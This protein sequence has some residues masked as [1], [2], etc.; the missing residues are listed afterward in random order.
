MSGAAARPSVGAPGQTPAAGGES[1]YYKNLLD[2]QNQPVANVPATQ[3]A[4]NQPAQTPNRPG[5][6]PPGF[7]GMQQGQLGPEMSRYQGAYDSYMQRFGGGGQQPPQ[8]QSQQPP[9][10]APQPPAT[11]APQAPMGQQ[12]PAPPRRPGPDFDRNRQQPGTTRR[13]GI[14]M[15]AG[16]A[17]RD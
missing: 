15:G 3:A 11:G 12:P 14:R 2:R 8:D 6:T 16:Y 17:S 4:Q 7:G 9:G 1:A 5:P 10:A 13:P